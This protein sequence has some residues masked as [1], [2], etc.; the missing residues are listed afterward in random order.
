MM[1]NT[2]EANASK[3]SDET[4]INEAVASTH[5]I[6]KSAAK[7]HNEQLQEEIKDIKEQQ[8]AEERSHWKSLG[9]V[10][11]TEY[12]PNCNSPSGYQSSSGT[13]LY[14]GCVACSWLPIG[15]VLMIDGYEYTVVDVCGTDAIDIFVDTDGC[16]CSMNTYKEVYIYEP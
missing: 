1:L 4:N 3:I 12:C 7:G 11:C 13:Y 2:E 8:E 16:Y 15:T 9:S 6:V 5:K 10:R 14:E